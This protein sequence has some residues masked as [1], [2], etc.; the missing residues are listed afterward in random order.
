MKR[1]IFILLIII[2]ITGSIAQIENNRYARI[3]KQEFTV[4]LVNR[5]KFVPGELGDTLVIVRY[6][7]PKL[8]KMQNDARKISFAKNG[9][10]T[11]GLTIES[12]IT[13]RDFERMKTNAEK[14]SVWRPEYLRKKLKKKGIKSLI[15]DENV[16]SQN[17][18]Y[19]N[20]FWFK[21]LYICDQ[22]SLEDNGWIMTIADVFYDPKADKDME[23]F[24]PMNYSVLDLIK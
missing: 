20:K 3:T 4:L 17:L 18:R 19:R 9:A 6:T 22:K 13:E 15:V 12:L 16:L 1:M 8:L 2:P 10:D 11:T 24:L 23:V 14:F 21:T 7:G 5:D